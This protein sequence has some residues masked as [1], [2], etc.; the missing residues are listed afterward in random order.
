MALR[1]VG[2]GLSSEP[3]V[4]ARSLQQLLPLGY[5]GQ[6]GTGL[7]LKSEGTMVMSSPRV[8]PSPWDSAVSVPPRAQLRCECTMTACVWL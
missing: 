7:L 5:G 2:P 6:P 1:V 8:Q 4:S 3:D